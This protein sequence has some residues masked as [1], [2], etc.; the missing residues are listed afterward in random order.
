MAV[1]SQ[2]VGEVK[3]GDSVYVINEKTV[4]FDE[5]EDEPCEVG[6]AAAVC[7]SV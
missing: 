1:R 5:D 7:V 4:D 2:V 6:G 3:K